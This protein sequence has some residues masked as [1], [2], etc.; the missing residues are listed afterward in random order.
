MII[1]IFYLKVI[2]NM[3]Y[4]IAYKSYFMKTIASLFLPICFYFIK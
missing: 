1:I 3:A 4:K 2:N